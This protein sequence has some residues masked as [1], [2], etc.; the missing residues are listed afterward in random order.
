MTNKP[1]GIALQ[2]IGGVCLIAAFFWVATDPLWGG[3]A[4]VFSIA[5]IWGGG[6][7]AGRVQ[8]TPE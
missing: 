6:R 2:L 5:V 4:V 7:L 3:I 1:A 8:N